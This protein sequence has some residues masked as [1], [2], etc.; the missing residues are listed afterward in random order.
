MRSLAKLTVLAVIF[1]AAFTGSLFASPAPAH[2]AGAVA[3][4]G[5]AF[6]TCMLTEEGGVKCWGMNS[7][8]QLGDGTTENRST[9]VDVVGLQSGVKQV[10]AGGIHTCALMEDSTVKCW[11]NLFVDGGSDQ[12][13]TPSPVDVCADAACVGPL[14]GIASLSGGFKSTCAVTTL[15][16]AKCWGSNMSS[17]LGDGTDADSSVPVDVLSVGG[18]PLSGVTAV[19]VGTEAACALLDSGSVTCW[20][21]HGNLGKDSLPGPTASIAIGHGRGCAVVLPDM[22]AHCWGQ[23]NYGQL[24]DGT[25]L[26]RPEAVAVTGLTAGVASM[27]AGQSAHTCAVTLAGA[28]RCWGHNVFGQLGSHNEEFQPGAYSAVPVDVPGY[29]SGVVDVALGVM[30]TCVLMESGRV[31]CWGN[32]HWGQL[33]DADGDGYVKVSDALV[34]LQHDAGMIEI[35]DPAAADVNEDADVNSVDARLILQYKA[36]LIDSLE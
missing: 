5:G 8:G 34:I 22:S 26:Y 24:G 36:G 33:G 27:S 6:H 23:N 4:S 1:G 31:T 18:V 3:I 32:D 35:A 21:E 14:S 10:S 11:G 12:A 19:G 20:G 7:S 9:P 2:G 28:L 30:H 16:T 15:G 29:D 17:I 25:T 13:T